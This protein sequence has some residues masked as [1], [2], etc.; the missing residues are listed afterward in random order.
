MHVYLSAYGFRGCL[1]ILSAISLHMIPIGM[2]L[3][4]P[5]D[6]V[7]N[8]AEMKPLI[9]SRKDSVTMDIAD[10]KNSVAENSYNGNGHSESIEQKSTQ[11]KVEKEIFEDK[12]SIHCNED[13]N[14][15]ETASTIREISKKAERADLEVE[16][17]NK[18]HQ[19]KQKI[20]ALSYDLGL[21]LLTN[22]FYALHVLA[23]VFIVLPHNMPPVI[24][25]DHILWTGL[26]RNLAAAS[27]V[28]IGVANTCSRFFAWNISKESPHHWFTT[29]ALSSIISG[30][31]LACTFF[32][33]TYWMY[34]IMCLV[35]GITRGIYVIH[36][37]LITVHLVGKERNHHAWGISLT[38][39]GIALLIGKHVLRSRSSFTN[40]VIK[41]IQIRTFSMDLGWTITT[42]FRTE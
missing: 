31:A 8:N 26:S 12:G 2:L 10:I 28:I 37:A 21:D 7:H 39:R 9:A 24:L 16:Q 35:F 22:K 11:A 5:S 6:D 14:E 18:G 3:R 23:C 38:I 33:K 20:C 27:L 36:N 29:M 42:I 32:Y 17:S 13:I 25:P 34:I 41:T 30:V 40:C 1:W 19:F 15:K 4:K